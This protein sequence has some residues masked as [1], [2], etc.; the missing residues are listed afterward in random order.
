M[1]DADV[2]A[3]HRKLVATPSVSHDEGAIMDLTEAWLRERGARPVRFGQNVFAATGKGPT[4]VL[5]THL[6]TVPPTSAWTRDPFVP[7]VVDGRVYGLGSNDAKASAAAMTGVFLRAASHGGIPGVT[8]VLA[9]VCEEETGGKGAEI[10]VPELVRRG[11]DPKAAIIGEPTGL[12]VATAQKGLLALELEARATPCHAANARALGV[13]NPIR[14]VAGDLVRLDGVN[15]GA[16]HPLLGPVTLEPTVVEAGSARNQVPGRAWVNI[17]VRTNPGEAPDA[18]FERLRSSVT[19]S[20]L[21]LRSSR[22]AARE[23]ASNDPIVRA[24]LDVSGRA[25]YGSRG[26]SDWVWFKDIPAV[27]CGPGDTARSHSADEWVGESEI[28]DGARFYEAAV[29]RWV[30]LSATGAAT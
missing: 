4:V 13:V 21:R 14:A 17:D 23:T 3:Y 26:L 25:P 1:N 11:F 22:L 19:T 10:V 28:L 15:L 18:L 12:G 29:R 16:D 8:L 30:A 6:D 5:C 24:A 9:L 2:L 27:K 7:E 20:E